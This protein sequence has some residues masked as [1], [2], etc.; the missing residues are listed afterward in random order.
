MRLLHRR[1]QRRDALWGP[2]VLDGRYRPQARS[3]GR[4]SFEKGGALP[5]GYCADSVTDLEVHLTDLEIK[6]IEATH[7][8]DACRLMSN[9]YR[10]HD[11]PVEKLGLF[12]SQE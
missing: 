1:A 12:I 3:P 7:A 5:T 11:P 6:A 4:D 2:T 8:S 9:G 10:S